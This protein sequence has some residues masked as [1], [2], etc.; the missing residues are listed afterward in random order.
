MNKI[1]VEERALLEGRPHPQGNRYLLH[2]S[3]KFGPVMSKIR[4]HPNI[5]KGTLEYF[6]TAE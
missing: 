3:L 5:E 6:S 1:R 4:V 2:T